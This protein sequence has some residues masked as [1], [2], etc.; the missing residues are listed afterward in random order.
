MIQLETFLVI[1]HVTYIIRIC[2]EN[3]EGRGK[4]SSSEVRYDITRNS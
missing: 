1:V 2:I 4:H 3:S